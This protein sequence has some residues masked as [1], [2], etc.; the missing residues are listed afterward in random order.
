[1]GNDGKLSLYNG[2]STGNG[3]MMRNQCKDC[4]YFQSH[5][6]SGISGECHYGPPTANKNPHGWSMHSRTKGDSWCGKWEPREDCFI[7][8][9]LV[10]SAKKMLVS[11]DL[12]DTKA[13]SDSLG[14]LVI[15]ISHIDQ[16]IKRNP[17]LKIGLQGYKAVNSNVY[18]LE[19]KIQYKNQLDRYFIRSVCAYS[20]E[21]LLLQL[22]K[23]LDRAEKILAE[24]EY[25]NVPTE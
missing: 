5:R 7:E 20:F 15:A 21:Q 6:N 11:D 17:N 9:D 23:V 18:Y 19:A 14:D 13:F 22:D 1:M 2:N 8:S 4:I 3:G 24:E 16:F 25:F 12:K 10:D